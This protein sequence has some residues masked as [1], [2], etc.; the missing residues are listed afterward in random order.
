[1][2]SI[3]AIS[4]SYCCAIV[5]SC[6]VRLKKVGLSLE[7]APCGIAIEVTV[8]AEELEAIMEL[9]LLLPVVAPVLPEI[10]RS[11][12]SLLFPGPEFLESGPEL[13]EPEPEFSD[14]ADATISK[15]FG[16]QDNERIISTVDR[17][18]NSSSSI[19]LSF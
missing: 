17:S 18:H 15:V 14:V 6:R 16:T 8:A 9:L 3:V 1:M 13:L 4:P 10:A 7:A 11:S 2:W 12:S 19:I 5:Y